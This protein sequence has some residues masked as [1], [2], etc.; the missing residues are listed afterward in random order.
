MTT[1]P[2]S[3]FDT[4]AFSCKEVSTV[5]VSPAESLPDG[6]LGHVPKE[7]FSPKKIVRSLTS[8]QAW[9]GDYV[10]VLADDR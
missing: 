10:S 6:S 5:D 4:D 3:K 7:K 1:T 2:D 8:R 9:F